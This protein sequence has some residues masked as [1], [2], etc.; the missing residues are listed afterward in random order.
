[1]TAMGIALL[2]MGCARTATPVGPCD[3]VMEDHVVS[4]LGPTLTVV[5]DIRANWQECLVFEGDVDP[6]R[7]TTYTFS[8][9]NNLTL[10]LLP[11]DEW[12]RRKTPNPS[13]DKPLVGLG[14]EAYL[15]MTGGCGEIVTLRRGDLGFVLAGCISRGEESP[16]EAVVTW[17]RE[18]DGCLSDPV[19]LERKLTV[20]HLA[21]AAPRVDVP[22]KQ[23]LDL[24]SDEFEAVSRRGMARSVLLEWMDARGCCLI[25]E[26][27]GN[28][29]AA[30][31]P[32]P[33]RS[34]IRAMR[35]ELGFDEDDRLQTSSV[36]TDYRG[37]DRRLNPCQPGFYAPR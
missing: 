37:T 34:P 7:L 24:F 10:R 9:F 26:R 33:A 32:Q 35:L 4:F 23:D 22:P 3:Y 21:I 6:A 31:C 19:C 30:R 25:N 28:P 20:R 29:L 14:D 18:L 8:S 11:P 17:A 15:L 36:Q 2:A 16:N 13:L 12:Q 27:D 5:E 1:M